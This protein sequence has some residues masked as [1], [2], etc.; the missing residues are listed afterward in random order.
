LTIE[1]NFN[2]SALPSGPL[3]VLAE[4][5][6]LQ[7]LELKAS[8]LRKSTVVLLTLQR[9][10]DIKIKFSYCS[11]RLGMQR[12]LSLSGFGTIQV[13]TELDNCGWAPFFLL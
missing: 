10:T 7:V 8:V 6:S 5:P 12:P 3:V 1:N 4:S 9:S 2:Y 13:V 11:F